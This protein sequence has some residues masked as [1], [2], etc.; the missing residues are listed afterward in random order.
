V[1]E[2]QPLNK[3]TTRIAADSPLMQKAIALQKIHDTQKR[4][5]KMSWSPNST[6]EL[7]DGVGDQGRAR[8]VEPPAPAK[9]GPQQSVRSSATVFW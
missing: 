7:A 8:A 9:N 3:K 6:M 1:G 2:K 4:H 5:T